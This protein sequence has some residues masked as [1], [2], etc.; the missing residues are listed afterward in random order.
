MLSKK[1]QILLTINRDAPKVVW[2][3]LSSVDAIGTR[4][5]VAGAFGSYGWSAEAVEMIK[6]RLS[7]LKYNFFGD[8]IKANFMPSDEDLQSIKEYAIGIASEI[9]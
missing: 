8:G 7:Q 3:V 9:K 1:K 5:K 6:T 4:G 2:D